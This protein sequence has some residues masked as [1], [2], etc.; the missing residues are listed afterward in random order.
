MSRDARLEREGKMRWG[1]KNR[2][3]REVRPKEIREYRKEFLISR[4]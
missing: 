1:K 4:I 2:L 3:L